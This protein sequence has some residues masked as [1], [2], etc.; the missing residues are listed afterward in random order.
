MWRIFKKSIKPFPTIKKVISSGKIHWMVMFFHG[1][2]DVNKA[3]LFL[4][5]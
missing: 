4:R 1:T 5:V 2:I 3:P